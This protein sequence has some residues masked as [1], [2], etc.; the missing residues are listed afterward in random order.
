MK[1]KSKAGLIFGILVV[2]ATTW[3]I[4]NSIQQSIAR[5]A[6]KQSCLKLEKDI[7]SAQSG[8]DSATISFQ[9]SDFNAKCGDVVGP[10]NELTVTP[11]P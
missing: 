3:W 9:A 10:G 1:T 11:Q 8:E 4:V 6:L 7:L 2:I 5:D